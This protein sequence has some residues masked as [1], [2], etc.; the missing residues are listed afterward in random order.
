[1]KIILHGPY[2]SGAWFDDP[3]GAYFADYEFLVVV[4]SDKLAD[5]GEF[6][7]ECERKLLFAAADR[8]HLRTYARLTVH[9]FDAVNKQIDQGSS[10]FR[11]IIDNG[12]VLH[13]TA[14][15]PFPETG[16][17]QPIDVEADADLHLEE[18][19][20]LLDEF[21]G[22][23]K[24]SFAN[25]W[26][27]KAAFDLHQATERLYNIVLLVFTGYTPHTHNLV[28]LRRLAEPL[29][30]RLVSA[31]PSD[32]KEH[33]RCFELLRGAYIRARYNRYYRVTADELRWLLGQVE[34][35]VDLVDEICWERIEGLSRERM[36]GTARSSGHTQQ[37]IA[38]YYAARAAHP[39][40]ITDQRLLPYSKSE[41]KD[42]ILATLRETND[43][44]AVRKLTEGF[45]GLAEWLLVNEE[46]LSVLKAT[47]QPALERSASNI[48]GY[49]RLANRVAANTIVLG[50][51]LERATRRTSRSADRL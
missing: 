25:G 10:Y 9:S 34:Y 46:E 48:A 38:K 41:I 24:L 4:S 11:D 16:S 36:A 8:V 29:D 2:A 22:S 28:Q 30:E 13:D 42:A 23:A 31:W 20:A 50:A 6:W 32:A 7:S 27:R 15:H 44:E 14:E 37:V 49:N 43:L 39:G 33:R 12:V 45:M 1:M 21:L 26:Y 40:P 47:E 35:L 19:M 17:A 18:G 5:V 51:E 3:A